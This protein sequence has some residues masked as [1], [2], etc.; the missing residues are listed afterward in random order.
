MRQFR[1]PIVNRH[2]DGRT[3]TASLYRTDFPNHCR[4]HAIDGMT[5]VFH[6]LSGA[7]HFLDRPVPEMLALLAEV[8]MDT[9]A[10][11]RALCAQLD[12]PHDEEAQA[13]VEARL[14]ELVAIGLV[15]S[16]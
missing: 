8:P 6:R 3:V 10:L 14:A 2:D 9:A 13:V 15:Q 5:L 16:G 4:T 1:A 11:T 7:T 12:L